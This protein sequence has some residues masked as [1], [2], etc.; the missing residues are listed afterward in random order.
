[1]KELYLEIKEIIVS[2]E[3]NEIKKSKILQY[4]ENDIA[5]AL[6]ELTKEERIK[7]Y[8]ILE[9][10]TVSL[11][12]AYLDNVEEYIEEISNQKAAD[13]IE[14][15]DADDAIDVLE[16]LDEEKSE[17]IVSLMEPESV[18]DI[19][20][21]NRY[22]EDELGSKM[23]NNY[24]II[25]K[26]NTIRSA[27]KS[28][29]AQ[30]ADND[31]VAIIYVEDECNKYYGAIDLRDLI[32]SREKDDLL[33]IIKQ[34]YPSFYATEN[35]SDILIKLTEYGQDSYPVLN[36]NDEVIGAFTYED[37]IEELEEEMKEDYAKLAG[38]T[39]EEDLDESVFQSVK[40]R[41]PWLAV[42]LFLSFMVS[43]LISRFEGVVS[44]I[45]M[46]V[47]FQSLILG[48][49]GNTGT[50]SLAVT[51]RLLSDEEINGKDV[52]KTIF[53]EIR[54]GFL[55]G[56]ILGILGFTFVFGFISITK[57]PIRNDVFSYVDAIEVASI[58]GFSLLFA[59]TF[60]CV[61]GSLIPIIF[62][63]IKID[64]AVASGPFITTLIDVIAVLI[65]YSL[66]TILFIGL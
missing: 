27:M 47:F 5:D 19:E 42:L 20:L 60:S 43:M 8:N 3:S 4:H 32:I 45:P 51:I 31:N 65:Y 40:K 55:N 1:M 22:K 41:I 12:F 23:T 38:L 21:I 14:L 53:K 28:V 24:I 54:V 56:L 49:A 25:S 29:I 9:D 10:E 2:S 63:K 7:L 48:M 57:Q 18:T 34:N 62:K 37:V 50:Q 30:A 13:I 11:I 66:A 16:E 64:P 36:E 59:M 39:E 46:I 35:I 61:V 44:T 17:E 52:L 58:V 15:M 26:D 6:S 33:N